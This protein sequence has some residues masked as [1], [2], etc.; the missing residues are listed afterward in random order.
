MR[1]AACVIRFRSVADR[2]RRNTP[3]T[4]ELSFT[5]G[6]AFLRAEKYDRTT[7]SFLWNNLV[8]VT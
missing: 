4:Y 8:K 5:E 1:N 7:P 2:L 6:G 3:D